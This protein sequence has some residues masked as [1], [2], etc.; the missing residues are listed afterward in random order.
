MTEIRELPPPILKTS[1]AGPLGGD[2]RDPERPPP[3]LKMSMVGPLGDY[4]GSPG[5]PITY[6]GDIDGGPHWGFDIRPW[7]EVSYDQHRQHR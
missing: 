7:T 4:A 1:M 5:A 6:L 3:I 2:D